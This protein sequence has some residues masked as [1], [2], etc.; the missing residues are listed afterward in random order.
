MV[1]GWRPVVEGLGIGIQHH[2]IT[3][4]YGNKVTILFRAAVWEGIMFGFLE[5]KCRLVADSMAY[6][7][8]IIAMV[9]YML[10]RR[11]K[12]AEM[13]PIVGGFNWFRCSSMDLQ[14]STMVISMGLVGL[15]APTLGNNYG[16]DS[17]CLREQ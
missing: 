4:P 9:V 6:T 11:S 16:F 7:T 1:N 13:S 5:Q 2:P 17:P 10:L 8:N 12:T 14:I 15:A 3:K